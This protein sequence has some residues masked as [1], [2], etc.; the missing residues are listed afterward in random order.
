MRAWLHAGVQPGQGVGDLPM[1]GML[2][3]QRAHRKTP[4]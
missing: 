1:R 4:G 2:L 3:A